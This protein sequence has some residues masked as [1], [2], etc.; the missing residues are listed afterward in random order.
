MPVRV[1]SRGH[2][3]VAFAYSELLDDEECPVCLER[4]KLQ[5]DI[6]RAVDHETMELRAKHT[7]ELIALQ[8]VYAN[9]GG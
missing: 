9:G 4:I 6:V 7:R 8:L 2:R 3:E 5:G 1:C